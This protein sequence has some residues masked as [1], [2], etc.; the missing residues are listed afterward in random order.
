MDG[1][2]RIKNS[3]M[4]YTQSN[5]FWPFI[6]VSLHL[7]SLVIYIIL[8]LRFGAVDGLMH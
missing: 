8:N 6:F 3:S 5:A 7:F 4:V 2:L 1:M